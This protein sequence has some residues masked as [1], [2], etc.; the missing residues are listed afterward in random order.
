MCRWGSTSSKREYECSAEA[1]AYAENNTND[2][3]MTQPLPLFGSDLLHVTHQTDLACT[4]TCLPAFNPSI[5][6]LPASTLSLLRTLHP[7][8]RY[9][10]SFRQ[11][12]GQCEKV[13]G[14][15]HCPSHI[16]EWDPATVFAILDAEL[17]VLA[18]VRVVLTNATL[19]LQDVRLHNLNGS[20]SLTFY[21]SY[22]NGDDQ[23]SYVAA[24]GLSVVG[25]AVHGHID[26]VYPTPGLRNAGLV[27][28]EDRL[29]FISW[30][31]QPV[32][33]EPA[34]LPS[35]SPGEADGNLT[36]YGDI[37]RLPIIGY[38]GYDL[39]LNGSPLHVPE[40]GQ[41]LLLT[42]THSEVRPKWK[43]SSTPL[44]GFDYFHHFVLFDDRPPWTARSMS[45]AWCFPA[46]ENSSRCESIQFGMSL[47]LD[48]DDNTT[49]LISYGVNDCSSRAARLP[50][51][52]A[53]ALARVRP[54]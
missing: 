39:H 19:Y 32:I 48:A 45:S 9:V 30:A 17:G 43:S 47:V 26:H 20:L 40:L 24:F 16:E 7:S 1:V 2:L 25:D 38:R 27:L 28:Y 29:Q 51:F 53:L 44:D 15:Q 31:T 37:Q 18:H 46:A 54:L 8:S 12:L 10:A 22:V 5:A 34:V 13:P 21:T 42:H 41:L 23:N 6:V 3:W 11:L 49:L 50:L 4:D 52:D 14:D 33:V 36:A 35:D